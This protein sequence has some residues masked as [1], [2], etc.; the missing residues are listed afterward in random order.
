MKQPD[1]G[2]APAPAQ[3]AQHAQ[4][5]QPEEGRAPAEILPVLAVEGRGVAL[6]VRAR[7]I[8]LDATR[9]AAAPAFLAHLVAFGGEAIA[10]AEQAAAN[11]DGSAYSAGAG[12]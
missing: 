6:G 8:A 7:R 3:S 11:H 4:W 5:E 1:S 2:G 12:R 9:A 10:V